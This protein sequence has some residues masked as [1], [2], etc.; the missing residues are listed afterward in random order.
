MTGFNEGMF[1][2]VSSPDAR[3]MPQEVSREVI[4]NAVEKSA[5]LRLA[6]VKR[7]PT[8]SE[9]M[10]VLALKPEA[11][12]L[13]GASQAAK[14]EA[15]KQTTHAE[16][17]NV[18]MV[19]QELAVLSR[20]PDA[21]V[22]DA[23]VDLLAELIPE[24]GEAF[25]RKIDAACLFGADSPFSTTTDGQSIYQRAVAA[26]NYRQIGT[27]TDIAGDV[28]VLARDLVV[29]GY[30][31]SGF[32]TE[33][34]FN[35]RLAAERTAQGLS[36]YSPANGVDRLNSSLYGRPLFEVKDGAWDS[37]R[38]HLVMGDWSRAIVGIRQDMTV[39]VFDQAVIADAAGKVI[40][41]A[42]QQD[43]KILRVVMRLAFAT[44]NY[45][46]ALSLRASNYPFAVLRPAAAPAS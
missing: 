31:S 2:D 3:E 35:W 9:R 30:D 46:T 44:V 39:R 11:Y 22:D 29:D 8:R 19:A 20:V 5:I 12:W 32:A 23:N 10:P 27:S 4:K 43:G 36:P 16:F 26:G 28:G 14:D 37:T 42:A 24:I 1:R 33:P 6:T 21:Y 38:A 18:Q 17:G 15:L 45:T 34:G 25:A 7:M 40:F 41:S 13:T